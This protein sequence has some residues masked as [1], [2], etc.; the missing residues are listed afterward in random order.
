MSNVRNQCSGDGGWGHGSWG[1]NNWGQH[2]WGQSSATTVLSWG[3]QESIRQKLHL[4]RV[5]AII[6]EPG[7]GKTL[8][9]PICIA[10]FLGG[11]G[12]VLVPRRV[13]A[14]RA[15]AR[16]G[17]G[18]V[19]GE[20]GFAVGSLEASPGTRLTYAT[21]GYFNQRYPSD[22]TL[23]DL[24]FVILDEVHERDVEADLALWMVREA[25][26]ERVDLVLQSATDPGC[27]PLGQ[28]SHS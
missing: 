4:S 20:V 27:A 11:K 28:P 18:M 9:V 2:T 1:Q 22:H 19:R 7:C 26:A 15:A 24:Q 6:G 25:I 5:I 23:S 8:G 12:M 13:Q 10:D 21:T 14:L 3:A 17:E 16:V